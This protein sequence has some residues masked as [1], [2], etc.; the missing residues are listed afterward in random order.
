MLHGSGVSLDLAQRNYD[1][2]RGMVAG[3]RLFAAKTWKRALANVPPQ[4][5]DCT[6]L[7]DVYGSAA[8]LEFGRAE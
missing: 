4:D 6:S 7:M 3:V 2:R 5:A 8:R 1:I